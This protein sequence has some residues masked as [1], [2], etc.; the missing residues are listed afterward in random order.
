MR[1]NATNGE[2]RNVEQT[3]EEGNTDERNEDTDAK[4]TNGESNKNETI[5]Y[6][7]EF[8][9]ERMDPDYGLLDTLLSNKTLS[10]EEISEIK[11][12]SSFYRKNSQLLDYILEKNQY[13]G[14][15]A[16][17]QE[18]EQVHLINYLNANGGECCIQ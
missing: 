12:K 10:S 13:S 14:L 8:L 3:N 17:L 7:R 15:I 6:H 11:I 1:T 9:K 4:E 16:A 5:K 18:N 2:E